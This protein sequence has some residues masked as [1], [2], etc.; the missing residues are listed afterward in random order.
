MPAIAIAF[1][2][3]GALLALVL[4]Q[5]WLSGAQEE[6]LTATQ[7]AALAGAREL[8]CDDRL[9]E[10]FDARH[11]ADHVRQVIEDQSFA[12][13][14]AGPLTAKLEVHLARVTV[15]PETGQQESEESDDDPNAVLVIGHRD[16]STSNPVALVGSV[17]TGRTAADV[18]VNVEASV[19]NVIDGVRP[20]GAGDVPAWPIAILEA[21]PDDRIPS[22][23]NQIEM[24]QGTDRYRWDAEK[25]EVVEEPDGL[26][27]MTLT[28]Q[29]ENVATNVYLVNIG[30]G[31]DT[32][33]L[34]QQ[35]RD[36]WST[37]NLED[38]NGE[39]TF[40]EGPVDLEADSDFDNDAGDELQRQIGQ[41]RI[42]LLYSKVLPGQDGL[43]MV[44]TT[45]FVAARLMA[46]MGEGKNLQFIVQ[47][48]V[49]AT[50]T[51]ML[52]EEALQQGDSQGNP[53]IY[54]ISITQ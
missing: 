36:G 15:D 27:E 6:L 38:L 12:N 17:F 50:R 54:K 31:F 1:L 9:K 13:Q 19:S 2:V 43:P 7:A 14:V 20:V 29:G 11:N 23:V 52:D 25:H 47:P 42:V 51:A 32:D 24:H 16:R 22:W 39:F 46:V 44:Q 3:C 30:T 49:V 4:N 18:T 33:Q 8:A 48:A 26:P 45:R 40:A 10:D 35:M 53:Y 34:V 5:Y 21:S 37:S 28:P 41:A